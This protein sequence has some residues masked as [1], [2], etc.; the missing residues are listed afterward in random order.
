MRLLVVCESPPTTH[1]VHGNGSTLIP[2]ATMP[3][4]S[5][6][7]VADL[8]YFADRPVGCDG[9]VVARCRSV[10]AL[11][12]RSAAAARTVGT[13]GRW[14][15][16]TWRRG[17]PAARRQVAAAARSADVVWL[18][19]L[20]TFGLLA[21]LPCPA[22]AFE[23]DPWSRFWTARSRHGPVLRRCYDRVQARRA[24]R[25]EQVAARDA[26]ALVVVGSDDAREL[27]ETLGRPVT[28]LPNGAP[29]V[30]R[31]DRSHVDPDTA[32]FV[33][34]LD[35]APNVAALH[36]LV[37]RLWPRL[38]ARHPRLRLEVVGRRPTPAVR[39]L[40]GPGITVVGAVEDLASVW[41]RAAVALFPGDQGQG[42]RN[43]V[44]EAVAAGCP[45]VAGRASVRGRRVPEEV[46]VADDDDAFLAAVGK[47]LTDPQS[48]ERRARAAARWAA[49]LPGWDV[50]AGQLSEL[51][52]Q[53]AAAGAARRGPDVR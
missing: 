43:T 4:L 34:T 20:H 7:I 32:V 46:A 48:R 38:R 42:V 10:A 35:Y 13:A 21:D 28:C 37:Q 2:A 40:A 51:L 25:L 53:A 52:E 6:G 18:H 3:R 36:Q 19:G 30:A 26:A 14:P 49:S 16:A 1:P 24:A 17:S 39:A 50:V 15:A 8:L 11:P 29:A 33:G 45:V 12:L 27:S 47:A 22:V 41:S 5:R 9:G 31:V 44:L 23:V